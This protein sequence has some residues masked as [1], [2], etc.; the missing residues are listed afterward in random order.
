MATV[1]ILGLAG[2]EKAVDGLTGPALQNRLRRGVRAGA[3]PFQAALRSAAASADVP[4]S[5][6]K[7]PAAKVSTHGGASGRDVVARVRPKSPLFNIFEPG[8]KRHTIAPRRAGALG[9]PAGSGTW[10][11]IGRKRGADFFSRGPVDH[12]GMAA[13]PLLP[14][15]FAAG[16]SAAQ[17]AFAAVVFGQER[18][19]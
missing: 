16:E 3:K 11:G 12:P 19:E 6:T 2:A 15:A 9:G 18:G 8:A 7:V 14:A 13:H 1:R 4:R 10:D 17:D 5:F